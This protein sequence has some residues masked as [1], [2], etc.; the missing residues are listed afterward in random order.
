MGHAEELPGNGDVLA[1]QGGKRAVE[2]KVSMIII[3]SEKGR[4]ASSD[5]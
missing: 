5:V 1:A 3:R 4:K 2:R